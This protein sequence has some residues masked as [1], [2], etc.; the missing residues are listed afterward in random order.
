MTR[1]EL[2]KTQLKAAKG[3]LKIREKELNASQRAYNRVEALIKNL[4]RKIETHLA[5]S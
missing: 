2:W 4:E 1:S 5:K 3:I